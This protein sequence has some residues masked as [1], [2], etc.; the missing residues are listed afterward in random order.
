MP[1]AF[2]ELLA[3]GK[4]ILADGATGTNLF[5]MGLMS[6][7]A[8]ELWNDEQPNKIRTL[9]QNFV[10]AGSDIILTN[11]FGGTRHRL[12]LHQA[13]SRVSE[14]NEK[15]AKLA[16]E[17]ADSVERPVAVAGSMGP[18][19][20]LFE[21][22]GAL[23]HQDAVDAFYEQA[24]ALAKG[25]ADVLWIETISSKEEL[26]AAFEAAEKTGLPV[27]TTLSFDTNG[28]TM[29]GITPAD[30]TEISP[31]SEKLPACYGANCGVGPAEL[32][33]ITISMRS[34]AGPDDIIIAKAN[35]GVPE[36]VDGEIQYS[37][38][39]DMMAY[40]AGLAVDC[41]AKIIGG[42]CGTTAVH[43]AAMRQA[44][45]NYSPQEVPEMATIIERL[46]DVTRGAKADAS[47][48]ELVLPKRE[49]TGRRR[50]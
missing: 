18:T 12:K 29:M 37:G 49:R 50:S 9:H 10:D 36:F 27:V 42:C 22:L 4:P 21:P 41:G 17:V 26:L 33:A 8:P 45:D 16:K 7:D 6:G 11:S 14:L 47:G 28:R 3:S 40:Y 20:E 30:L 25:G 23:T 46:G 38:T 39:V 32:I 2:L 35:C 34:S 19:G 24:A 5:A 1:N 44:L 15:A 48:E 13:D 43:V 31:K